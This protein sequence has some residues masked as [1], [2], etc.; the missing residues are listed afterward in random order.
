MIRDRRRVLPRGAATAN[1]A[2][3]RASCCPGHR[4]AHR[5]SNACRAAPHACAVGGGAR[6]SRL[7]LAPAE[8]DRS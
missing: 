8:P 5:L 2:R 1:T 7:V 6:T 3:Q 4:N